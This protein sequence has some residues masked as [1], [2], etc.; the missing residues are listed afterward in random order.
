[1]ITEQEQQYRNQVDLLLTILPYVAEVDCFALKGGTAI[2]LFEQAVPRMSVDIDLCY[3]ILN[4]RSEALQ[5]I[6][7]GLEQI[8]ES[9]DKNLS[10][11]SVSYLIKNN[12][13]DIKLVCSSKKTKV[14]VEV[15]TSMRGILFPVREMT[16]NSKVEEEF[17]KFVAINVVSHEELWGGKICAALDR[18]HPRDL[19]DIVHLFESGGITEQIKQGFTFC[20]LGHCRPVHEV[21]NPVM[22]DQTQSFVSQFKGMSQKDFSYSDYQEVRKRLFKE[23][24]SIFT[25]KDKEFLLSFVE[26]KPDWSLFCEKDLSEFPAIK[27][28]ML[29]LEK[30]RTINPKKFKEQKESLEKVLSSK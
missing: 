2:N 11:I 10:G 21:L 17:N 29:N 13:D 12:S 5:Q 14:K 3:S 25:K 7:K 18:Q 24:I 20:L 15:N 23:I 27:W 4:S 6:K 1:M 16:I 19:F 22:L 8:K 9:I 28:K 26:L 30:L